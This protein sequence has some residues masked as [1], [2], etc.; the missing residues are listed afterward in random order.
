MPQ[1][2]S[3]LSSTGIS[4]SMPCTLELSL[5]AASSV[6]LAPSDVPPSTALS[7]PRWSIRPCTWAPK[8]VIE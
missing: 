5:A 7:I 1:A 6:A 2:S 4:I 3:A 8:I